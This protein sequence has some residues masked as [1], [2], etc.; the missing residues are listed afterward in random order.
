MASKYQDLIVYLP[1]EEI[2]EFTYDVQELNDYDYQQ[3]SGPLISPGESGCQKISFDL[4]GTEDFYGG[5]VKG[6]LYPDGKFVGTFHYVVEANTPDDSFNGTYEETFFGYQFIGKAYSNEALNYGFY[7]QI[8]ISNK[9]TDSNAVIIQ[10]TEIQSRDFKE[11]QIKE[12]KAKNRKTEVS[13]LGK[14]NAPEVTLLNSILTNQLLE[15]LAIKMGKKKKRNKRISYPIYDHI[16]AWNSLPETIDDLLIAMGIAYSW[17][18]TMLDIYANDKKQLKQILP[19]VKYL[20]TI[21]NL[22]DFDKN[23]RKIEKCLLQ[24]TPVI[25]NSIVGTST[26]PTKILIPLQFK[27]SP[28]FL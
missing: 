11:I 10:N 20:G 7:F 21:K 14:K 18:P 13:I 5:Y 27:P 8:N 15:S 25:N 22:S 9:K 24:L 4:L 23:A 17:M 1:L 26:T 2:G 3:I 16:I 19:L 28:V 12:T 6:F